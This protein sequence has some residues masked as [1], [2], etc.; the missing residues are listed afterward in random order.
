M[1]WSRREAKW[2]FMILVWFLMSTLANRFIYRWWM[3]WMKSH[4]SFSVAQLK[5]KKKK[6]ECFQIDCSG[7]QTLGW[8]C[9]PPSVAH[10]FSTTS[11]YPM[12]EGRHECTSRQTTANTPTQPLQMCRIICSFLVVRFSFNCVGVFV[13]IRTTRI[14]LSRAPFTK[15]KQRHLFILSNYCFFFFLF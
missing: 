10:L 8:G 4:S 5:I 2:V 12:Y 7:T 15:E 3:R 6:K 9:R 1:R 13:F 14:H 11:F